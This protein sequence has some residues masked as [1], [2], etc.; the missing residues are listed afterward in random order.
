MTT[1]ACLV[2]SL[3]VTEDGG[4]GSVFPGIRASVAHSWRVLRSNPK[5]ATFLAA[6]TAWEGTFAGART[7]VVLYAT[8]SEEALSSGRTRSRR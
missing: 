5:V 8:V 1:G 4:H 7:F 2:P 6:N 3:F